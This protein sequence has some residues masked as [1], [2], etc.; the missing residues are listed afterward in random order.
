M[1]DFDGDGDNDLIEWSQLARQTIRWYECSSENKLLPAQSL[2]EHPVDGFDVLR[3]EKKAAELLLLGGSAD[4]LLRRY[5]LA[6]GETSELGRQDSLPLAGGAKTGWCG[7]KLDGEPAIVAVDNTQPRLRVHRL[8]D[9]GWLAEQTYPTISGIRAL[10]SPVTAPGVLLIWTKDAG[11]LHRSRWEHG[12]LTYPEP[13]REESAGSDRKVLALETVGDTTWWAIRAGSDTDLFVWA[14][15]KKEPEKKRF[16]GLGTKVDKLVWLGGDR[17]VF[18]DAYSTSAKLAT[19]KDGKVVTSTSPT[20][21][22]VDLAE[23]QLIAADKKL[24]GA[25]D[26]RCLAMAR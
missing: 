4:G 23:Y 12:R 24:L 25:T 19:I 17:I 9:N 7:I 6:R 26:R 21:A 3:R 2:H 13:W 18:Q 14:A 22:K 11:E 1:V 16:Q 20:L 15:G 5:Q 10:A 8:G